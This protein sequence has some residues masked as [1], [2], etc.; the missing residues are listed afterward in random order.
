ML[1]GDGQDEELKPR[2]LPLALEMAEPG[3][4]DNVGGG[5]CDRAQRPGEKPAGVRRP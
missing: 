2:C 1:T 4:R 5:V 3:P